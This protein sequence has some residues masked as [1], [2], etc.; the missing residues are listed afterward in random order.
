MVTF[1][2]RD[3]ELRAHDVDVKRLARVI[4]QASRGPDGVPTI[5][6][7]KALDE[8]CR[9]LGANSEFDARQ[10]A[11]DPDISHLDEARIREMIGERSLSLGQEFPKRLPTRFGST[12]QGKALALFE[13]AVSLR[14]PQA[15]E[16]VAVI[17]ATG[18]G[19]TL[20]CQ[21]A[22]AQHGGV[23]IDRQLSS[24][25]VFANAFMQAEKAARFDAGSLLVFDQ[26]VRPVR[27]S[28]QKGLFRTWE[29]EPV[30]ERTL[31]NYI[32]FKRSISPGV[33]GDSPTAYGAASPRDWV[34]N[35]PGATLVL[36]F[37]T[38]ADVDAALAPFINTGATGSW[39]DFASRNWRRAHVVDLEK[40]SVATLDGPGIEME[41]DRFQPEKRIA[42]FA[43]QSEKQGVA[44]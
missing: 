18:T 12:W 26:C 10:L 30:R 1:F 41:Q 24:L 23:V 6:M 28:Q 17:G 40:M 8:I 3:G 34:L 22:C 15:L 19:K 13:K 38:L 29:R 11:S 33:P 2:L 7:N 9:G 21:H 39:K 16:F 4:R 37:E 25:N 27:P 44:E 5:S 32:E 36:V 43:E 35:H 42:R 14:T 20:L 31:G